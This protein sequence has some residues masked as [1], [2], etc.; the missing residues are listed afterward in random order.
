MVGACLYWAV[1]NNLTRTVALA[2]ATF[3]AMSKGLTAGIV[4]VALALAIGVALPAAGLFAMG[5]LEGLFSC[6]ISL[7]LF[8]VA[9]RHLGTAR[10]GAY[11]STAPFA[12][13]CCPLGCL[14]SPSHGSWSWP[15]C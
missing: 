6:G 13:R 14:A 4:N 1:D 2:D 5:A 12:A 8:V 11:F 7:V 9:L 3:I 10:T 15:R